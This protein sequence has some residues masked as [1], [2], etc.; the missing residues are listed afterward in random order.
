VGI[1]LVSLMSSCHSEDEPTGHPELLDERLRFE[2]DE[3]SRKDVED[4]QA[5][6]E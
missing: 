1:P 3:N 2:W 6:F 5:M 4:G